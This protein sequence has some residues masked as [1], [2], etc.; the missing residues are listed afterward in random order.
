[1]RLQLIEFAVATAE[2]VGK[3]VLYYQKKKEQRNKKNIIKNA[4]RDWE[5][6]RKTWH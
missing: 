4:Q 2:T 5:N 6:E 1:M 3:I